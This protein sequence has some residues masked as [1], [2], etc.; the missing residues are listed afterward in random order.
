MRS[1][2]RFIQ[3]IDRIPV[4][5]RLTLGHALWMALILISIGVGVS[6]F[7]KESL[8]ESLDA[9]LVT[10][11]KTMREEGQGNSDASLDL[12]NSPFWWSVWD[13]FENGRRFAVRSYPKM[14]D[15][16]GN[17][18]ARTTN[19][20]VRLPVTPHALTRAEKG[21]LTFETFPQ[22][23]DAAAQLRQV[24]LPV[25]SK[26][27]FTGELIQVGTPL[28]P[29]Q[30][31]LRQMNLLL[32]ISF[33][34]A[35]VI[36]VLL[37]YQLTKAAFSPVARITATAKGLSAN[38]LDKRIAVTCADDELKTLIVTF[39]QMLDRLEDAFSRLRRFAGDVSHEL[40]TPLAVLRGEAELALRRER[41]PEQYKAAL[42]TIQSESASMTKVVEDLLLLARAQGKSLQLKWREVDLRRFVDEIAK[43]VEN[44]CSDRSVVLNI[45]VAGDTKLVAGE[46]YLSLAI[47]NIVL[48]AL[49]HSG[50]GQQVDISVFQDDGN[51]VFE[52]RDY[53]EG[54]AEQDLPYLFDA[55]YRADNA[56]NRKLGGVGIGLSL[57]HALVKLHGG[58]ID[59]DSKVGEGACFRIFVPET[60]NPQPHGTL[61]DGTRRAK[62]LSKLPFAGK[63]KD[64]MRLDTSEA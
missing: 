25:M 15:T 2:L 63:N 45:A 17:I 38:D 41:T 64:L 22:K 56:R 58:R 21:L 39:N 24:T 33:S 61:A 48:N 28:A 57:A 54:I 9:A 55:F 32:F 16:S 53:G 29:S 5:L 52:V 35:L 20:S 27:R 7:L 31:M 40:R 62:L 30:K 37:G 1:R 47:K 46:T 43:D 4:R 60:Q 59:V 3:I 19:M 13:E 44:K 11:A 51:T 34:V 23:G 36:S 14:V 49:K 12:R 18:S 26:G 6:E 42:N 10:S 50:E 8:Q